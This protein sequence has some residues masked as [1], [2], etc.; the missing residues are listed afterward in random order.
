MRRPL[1]LLGF[2]FLLAVPA[3]RAQNTE[4]APYNAS[5]TASNLCNAGV[6]AT[7]YFQPLLGLVTSGGDPILGT[8]KTLGGFPHFTLGVRANATSLTLP[9]LSYNGTTDTVN[10]GSKII[11]PAPVVEGSIGIYKG[12]GAGL[13][14]VDALGS[15]VL[16]PVGAVKDL[17][18][19]PSATKIGDVVLGLGYG[20]RVGILRGTGPIPSI[21]A[22]VM[23]RSI[24][25]IQYGD[26][27]NV[28]GQNFGYSLDL[29]ATSWRVTASTHLLILDVAA[30]AG[31]TTYTGDAQ[32]LFR[33]PIVPANIDSV[34]VKLNQSRGMVF[35]DAGLDLFILKLVGEVG[36]ESA[37]DLSPTTHFQDVDPKKGHLFGGVGVRVSF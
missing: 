37:G 30:G 29:H 19:D 20:L 28:A 34:N 3:L 24:P 21:S 25:K 17:H 33:D 18:V 31:Y 36:W 23:R 32:I 5:A 4:C 13:L 22:S 2:G 35:A 11:L 27:A 12:I 7:R 8:A 6:D 26:P 10:S 14:S 15:A 16:L 9:D 1:M